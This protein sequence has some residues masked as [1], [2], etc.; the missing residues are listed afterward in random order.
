[1]EAEVEKD[2]DDESTEVEAEEVEGEASNALQ[3]IKETWLMETLICMPRK[4]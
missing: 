4:A 2:E 3:K 1:V